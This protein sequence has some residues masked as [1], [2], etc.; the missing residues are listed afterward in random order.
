M[1]TGGP[2]PILA[3]LTTEGARD[4]HCIGARRDF[5]GDTAGNQIPQA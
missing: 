5:G 2:L 1:E 4:A 3:A